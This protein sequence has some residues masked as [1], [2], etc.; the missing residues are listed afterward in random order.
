MRLGALIGAV[1]VAGIA[2]FIGLRMMDTPPPPT[3]VA[4]PA[5]V[6]QV[7]TVNIYVAS[8]PIPIGST[9]TQEMLAIQPWPEH[10]IL[11]GFISADAPQ[12]SMADKAVSKT[13]VSA[14]NI[15]G[16]IARAPFQQQEPIISSKLANPND[17][18]F[19]S[20]ALPKGMRV[21]TIT[22]NESEGVAGFIFPG[23]HVDVILTHDVE[24]KRTVIDPGA[25][26]PREEKIQVP[27]TETLLTNVM[28]AAVDQRA[29]GTGA[30][31]KDG[32]L[33]IPR[34]I[35]LAVSPTDAQRLRLGQKVGTLTL[36]LRSLADRESSDPL[37]VTG[38]RDIS[39]AMD[40]ENSPGFTS[41]GSEIIVYRGIDSTKGPSTPLVPLAASAP[42]KQSTNGAPS[43]PA[44]IG[45]R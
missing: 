16:T 39:Q 24:K 44:P 10:L 19:L 42:T 6:Q 29:D 35:S 4:G 22:T 43:T 5:P 7:K 30:A 23:D 3:P 36:A 27:Y 26:T 37:S 18:N 13:S 38:P 9:I 1:A 2:A 12:Q 33:L 11:P 14:A 45:S 17:P 40:G 21:I 34:A 31:D 20:A 41:G 8:K 28:V 15:I 25:Q 32:K